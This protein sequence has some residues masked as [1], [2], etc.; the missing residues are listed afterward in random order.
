[1]KKNSFLYGTLVLIFVNFVVRFLGFAYRIIL[2]RMIGPEAIGIFHLVFPI[3]MVMI[4]FTSAG[5]PVAVSKLV[6]HFSSLDN[7]A[8]CKKVLGISMVIGLAISAVLS[9]LL[10][11]NAQFIAEK[12]IKNIDIQPSLMA[13]IPAITLITLSSIMRGYYYGIK[14]VG[15][16]GTSQILEQIFRIAFVIGILLIL[17]PLV[18]KY[19]S[20]IAILGISVGE[21]TGLLWLLMRFGDFKTSYIKRTY[22][23]FK[24]P[25]SDILSKIIYISIPITITRM[26]SVVM[27]SINAALIPQRLM[28]AGFSMQEAVAIFGKLSG[29]AMPLLFLPFIVTSALVVNIIP[30]VAEEVA[31]K[32]WHQLSLK[33]NIAIRMTLLVAIPITALLIFFASPI[34]NFLYQHADVG[35]YLSLLGYATVF[36][37]L[38]HVLSGILHGMGKQV[39]TTVNYLCGMLLQI[40]C[41]YYLVPHP[42]FGVKGF[43]IG[44]IL[45]TVTISLLNYIALNHYIKLKPKI[46]NDIGKPVFSTAIMIL[47]LLNLYELLLKFA[48]SPNA[49]LILSVL[50]GI[51]AYMISIFSTGCINHR[52]L[53]FIIRKK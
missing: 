23:Q 13:L 32:N 4:T 42:S 18:P 1:M 17:P 36:L 33:S 21:F 15:P 44:F 5:I 9:I 7:K 27:Q 38:Q 16:P 8:G 49:A 46:V 28:H 25:S 48:I 43:I 40:L 10:Y 26:I 19:A 50:S 11:F 29:M 6:A 35:E 30:S 2:S 41:T 34:C 3:L 53:Q 45:S 47:I 12:L 51:L 31:L 20:V 14:S 39:I 24:N 37:S 22:L 52:T